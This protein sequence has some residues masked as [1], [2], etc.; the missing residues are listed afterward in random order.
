MQEGCWVTAAVARVMLGELFQVPEDFAS[1]VTRLIPDLAQL[2]AG[3]APRLQ[4]CL[5]VGKAGELA[6]PVN[7]VAC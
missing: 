6:D 1:F 2:F 4:A 3:L 5:C 7:G